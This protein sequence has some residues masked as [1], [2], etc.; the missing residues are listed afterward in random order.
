[1]QKLKDNISKHL[2]KILIIFLVLQ[3]VLDVLSFFLQERG[4]TSISTLLRLL[5]LAAV[6][7]LGFLISDRKRV[8]IIFYSVAA[9]F[10]ILHAANCFRVGYTSFV[11]D[12]ANY[13]RIISL[14]IYTL[15]FITFFNKGKNIRKSIYTGISLNFLLVLLFTAIPWLIGQ[16]VYTYEWPL[17]VGIMGWFSVKSAQSAIIVL[18]VPL[19]LY[20]TYRT[21]KFLLFALA[22][23]L[24]MGLMFLTGTKFTFFSIFLIAFAF[25][26]ILAINLKKKS[27]KFIAPL[28]LICV[29]AVM[30]RPVSP[31][32]K[33]ER[34]S[35]YA[36]GNYETLVSDSIRSS[37]D[38]A[39]LINTIRSGKKIEKGSPELLRRLRKSLFG[40]YADKD[41]YG[42]V[43]K[44]L[45]ARFGVYNVMK[46]FEYTSEP[47]ILSDSRQKKTNFARMIWMEKDFATKLF[48]FEY[49]DMIYGENIYDLENDFP[50]VFYFCG[51]IGFALYLLYFAYFIF[52]VLRAFY[53]D[54][55][56]FLTVETGVIGMTF[57]L[58]A[59]AAQISGNVLR[60]P[61]VTAYFALIAAYLYDICI[62]N[63]A[64]KKS[65]KEW[66]ETTLPKWLNTRLE[67]HA[68][69]K[70]NKK[71]SKG[72]S[73]KTI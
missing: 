69:N 2:S 19:T 6:A 11:T 60:R 38:D 58:A 50:A 18:L 37:T 20:F 5:L 59:A 44:D 30:L 21:G 61:N 28:L 29:L 33:R 3:P 68:E 72:I 27:I 34:M 14:Q 1:M 49:E 7:F 73:K 48:G 31:M 71:A 64:D 12:T 40:V 17:E 25:M 65:W 62:N 22:G 24:T 13:L 26:F 35:D 8:Y 53:R 9:L 54:V 36:Q 70:A 39:D 4:N 32:Q 15:S 23:V 43:Y 63:L 47:S 16:P 10:W 56:G 41:V 57:I 45:N 66:K 51:Y 52:I 46:A 55:R 42:R 67:K